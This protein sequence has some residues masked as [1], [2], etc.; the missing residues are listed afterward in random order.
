MPFKAHSIPEEQAPLLYSL[1][2]WV[3]G[4][5]VFCSQTLSCRI[6]LWMLVCLNP[7]CMSLNYY[8]IS[9]LNYVSFSTSSKTCNWM[10]VIFLGAE[11]YPS[12][13]FRP[14][15][16]GF[17]AF[18]WMTPKE[19]ICPW[20]A[21]VGP[22]RCCLERELWTVILR[23]QGSPPRKPFLNKPRKSMLYKMVLTKPSPSNWSLAWIW[24][25]QDS[26]TE[27]VLDLFPLPSDLWVIT[28]QCLTPLGFVSD[29]KVWCFQPGW[30]NLLEQFS[31]LSDLPVL[32]CVRSNLN[33]TLPPAT[34][35]S[36]QLHDGAAGGP[37]RWGALDWVELQLK[38]NVHQLLKYTLT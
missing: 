28:S 12:Y 29:N 13:S 26:V 3:S 15:R 6:G 38:K 7:R 35:I 37:L 33:S 34:V 17:S 23:D 2:R 27:M 24:S 5:L 9:T 20:Q 11:L 30:K 22:K 16:Q 21:E 4:K 10:E 31:L 32:G 36:S 25:R 18:A 19:T 8:A 14:S 1:Q